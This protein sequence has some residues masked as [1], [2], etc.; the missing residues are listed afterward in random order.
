MNFAFLL[1]F[2]TLIAGLGTS[3]ASSDINW[4]RSV[5]CA[6]YEK[7]A[8]TVGVSGRTLAMK[9]SNGISMSSA[10]LRR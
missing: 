8:F 3:A 9:H 1:N 7:K 6:L 10:C 5:K 4:A 2:N